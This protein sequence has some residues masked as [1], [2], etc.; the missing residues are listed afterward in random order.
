MY[1][2]T[3][4]TIYVYNMGNYSMYYDYFTLLDNDFGAFT[5]GGAPTGSK[6]MLLIIFNFFV[7]FY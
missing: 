1:I 4:Y 6:F 5:S 7:V 2:Y 3:I